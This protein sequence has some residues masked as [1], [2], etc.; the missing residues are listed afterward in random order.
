MGLRGGVGFTGRG[1][2]Y[3]ECVGLMGGSGFKR[4]VWV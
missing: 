3:G 2:V 1:W 4:R